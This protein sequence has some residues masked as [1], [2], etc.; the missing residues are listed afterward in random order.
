MQQPNPGFKI[1][2]AFIRFNDVASDAM[3]HDNGRHLAKGVDDH[4][5]VS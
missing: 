2:G 5:K 3:T 1:Q 4:P